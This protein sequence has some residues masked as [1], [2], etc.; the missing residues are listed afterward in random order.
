M[1]SPTKANRLSLKEDEH[2]AQVSVRLVYG[3]KPASCQ[4][5][6]YNETARITLRLSGRHDRTPLDLGDWKHRGRPFVDQEDTSRAVG[7]FPTKRNASLAGRPSP[8][9]VEWHRCFC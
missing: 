9:L 1:H 8:L 3:L 4:S 6:C 5:H 2:G 7:E